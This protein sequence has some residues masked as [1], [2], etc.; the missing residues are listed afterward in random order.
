MRTP[1]E[2]GN[3]EQ[4]NSSSS[5]MIRF[6][7]PELLTHEM[8]VT[9]LAPS[10]LAFGELCKEANF[11]LN[12]KRATIKVLLSADVKANCV[13]VELAVV[14]SLWETASALVKQENAATALQILEWLGYITGGGGVTWTVIKFL[15]W[16]KN[17]K[18]ESVQ[19]QGNTVIVQVHGDNNNVTI[20]K[21]VYVL[22][23]D[24][25]IVENI[26]TVVHPVAEEH[27]IT[28]ATFIHNKKPQL[29]IDTDTARQLREIIGDADTVEPQTFTAHA[30]VHGV[31]FD[32]KSKSWRFKLNNRVEKVDISETT[33]AVDSMARGGVSVGDTYKAKIEMVERQTASGAY[34]T[35]FK[36]K[37]VVAFIPGHPERQVPL[38][39]PPSQES[40]TGGT[41]HKPIS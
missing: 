10:L 37:E 16:K 40:D 36:I 32:A 13:T 3:I 30:V 19:N 7:G 20:P 8:D 28:D 34:V 26:K 12:G 5:L 31:T 17:R 21:E 11:V 6:D 22:A 41:E 39:T 4:M 29:K 24:V 38:F 2:D 23:K 14:Q 33:I 27:G 9:L 15:L 1:A 25:K 18:E 35:D